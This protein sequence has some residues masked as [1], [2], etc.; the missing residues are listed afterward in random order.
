[1]KLRNYCSA[2]A[3]HLLELW[4]TAGVKLGYAP[5]PESKFRELFL[6]HPDFSSQLTF[7]LEAGNEI[8]GFVSGCTGDHIPRGDVRGYLTCLILKDE[9]NTAENTE[10]LLSAL[11]NGFR[12]LGRT[13]SAVTFFN[14]VRLPWILPGTPGHQHN[15]MPGIPTDIPLHDRMLA[16]GYREFA[17]ECAM[18][19]DL[20]DFHTPDWVE[21]KAENMA[22]KGY[23]VAPYDASIHQCLTEMVD[24]LQNPMWSAEIPAAGRDGLDLLVGLYGNTCAGFTGPVYPEETGRGYFAGIGVAPQYEKNGL[25][26]LLFYRL[27]E[28]EKAAGAQYM[29]LFTGEDNHAKQIYLGAGFQTLRT[30]G[31]MVKEL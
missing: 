7:L 4:N 15:N 27:L 17:R 26:T 6:D 30:F 10:L 31:V 1:M 9:A 12:K 23:T 19:L 8:L 2:D 28:R 20:K 24:T 21:K 22:E 5:L 16:L 14:P 13:Q 3:P 18:H 11:E 29:S 25:G